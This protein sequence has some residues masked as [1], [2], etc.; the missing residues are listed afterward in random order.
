MMRYDK[1]TAK[2]KRYKCENCGNTGYMEGMQEADN[3]A[4]I[5]P[6]DFGL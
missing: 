3:G 4:G 6:S 1:Q 2:G 5:N